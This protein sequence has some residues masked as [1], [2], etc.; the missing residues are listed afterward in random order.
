MTDEVWFRFVVALCI[1]LLVGVDRE[2]SKGDGPA[3]REAGI[4]TFALA[5]LLGALAYHLGGVLLLAAA[6]AAVGALAAVAYF[7]RKGDD[8]GLTTEVGLLATV[9]LG[10]LAVSEPLLAAALGVGLAVILAAKNSVHGFVKHVLTEAEIKDAFILAFATVV[11]WPVLPDRAMGPFDAINPNKVWSLVVLVMAVGAAGHIASR[12]LGGTYGLP[13]SG[14]AAGF[15]SSAA[16]IGAMGQR[17]RENAG[18]L[19]GAT[20][21]AALSTVA[22][23]IQ[24]ALLLAVVSPPVA[25]ALAPSLIAGGLAAAI[26]GLAFTWWAVR[27]QRTRSDASGRAFSLK[28]AL[29]LAATLCVMLVAAAYLQ[30]RV[31]EAGIVAG[32]ALAGF[33]DTHA[34]AISVASL[35]NTGRFDAANAV[36]PILAAMTCNGVTKLIMAFGAGAPSYGVRVSPGIVLSLAAAWAAP[37]IAAFTQP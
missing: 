23:F 37:W 8:P 35:A 25:M 3:R 13:L 30:Q 29:A 33:A 17:A 20:A 24:M 19:N 22:T 32:A 6:F 4:R 14:F 12:I 26:Y 2:R 27:T 34:A 31:G 36:T 1:G 21:G 5:A 10:G 9:L 16:T 11:I 7:R 15:A 18:E 28:T